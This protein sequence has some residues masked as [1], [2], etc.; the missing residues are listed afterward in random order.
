M[1]V[2]DQNRLVISV[3]DSAVHRAN[4]AEV[5]NVAQQ[6]KLVDRGLRFNRDDRRS[7]QLCRSESEVAYVRAAVDDCLS[8]EVRQTIAVIL[9]D[10][11][12]DEGFFGLQPR[13]IDVSF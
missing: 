9:K 1:L 3:A 8:L 13:T 12:V 10:L 11:L 4:V 2:R 7:S 6:T 5:L